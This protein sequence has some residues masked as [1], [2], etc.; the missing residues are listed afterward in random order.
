MEGYEWIKKL[1]NFMRLSYEKEE[2]QLIH[3][4]IEKAIVF[5]GTNFWILIFAIFIASV[6]LNMNSPA[7]VIGAMLISPLMG[8]INGVGYSVATYN[9]DLLKRSLKNY[10][11][12]VLGGLVAST[13]Y[14]YVSPIHVEHS[15][16]LSR[17]SPTIYDV[18]IAMFGG[19]AGIVAI[20]SKNKGNVIPG[21]AI[22]TALMPPLCTAGFGLAE[23]NMTFFLGAMYLFLI[24]SVFIALS[25]MLVSQLLKLPKRSFLL[26][27][28]IKNTN[29]LVGIVILL[30]V[31]PS[32]Y[33]GI[34]LVKKEKFMKSAESFVSKI[35]DWEG[36]Y[37]LKDE[38]NG[39]LRTIKLAYVGNEIDKE[40]QKRL[41]EKAKDMGLGDAKIYIQQGFQSNLEESDRDHQKQLDRL[42]SEVV[43][44]RETMKINQDKLDSL[45][46]KPPL[47]RDLLKE[48][49]A[50]LPQIKGCSISN[51]PYF[52]VD[53][54]EDK[55]IPTVYF[56]ID[57]EISESEREGV[58]RWLAQKLGCDYVV[59]NFRRI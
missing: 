57:D 18:F 52:T 55:T 23:G 41:E 8:P 36:N 49:S 4:S 2:S 5:R 6:G 17:T 50:I 35:G 28:E 22:A 46:T 29:I 39:D 33:L 3:D 16:L 59:L 21:V 24:N 31:I 20:C 1:F 56:T 40:S 44:V 37:L 34:T 15:E 45:A 53:S 51:E 38:V 11:F 25:A 14:F 27:R 12:A 13:L 19:L 32:V 26:S 10:S 7:V 42:Q 9:F 30:T 58:E 43:N 47:G 54:D 48:I